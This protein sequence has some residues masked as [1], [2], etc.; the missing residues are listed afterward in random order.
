MNRIARRSCEALAHATRL[1][2]GAS[3]A[4]VMPAIAPALGPAMPATREA[5]SQAQAASRTRFIACAI[6]AP[7]E[8]SET[9]GQK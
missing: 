3:A 6:G 4:K 1:G 9:S 8:P 7:A 5:K 2:T